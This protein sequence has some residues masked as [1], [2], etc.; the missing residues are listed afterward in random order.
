[1]SCTLSNIN[2]E[3]EISFTISSVNFGIGILEKL[4]VWIP[5]TIGLSFT[6]IEKLEFALSSA[7]NTIDKFSKISKFKFI[8]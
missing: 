2:W 7:E 3:I 4:L 1:M 6:A 8:Y 5:W